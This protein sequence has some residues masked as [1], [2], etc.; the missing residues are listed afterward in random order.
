[1]CR[2]MGMCHYLGTSFG[3]LSD[4]WVPFWAI[5]GFLGVILLVKFDFFWN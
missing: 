2:D 1:M 4:F 5:P 3:V